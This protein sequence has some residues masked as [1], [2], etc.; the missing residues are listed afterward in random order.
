MTKSMPSTTNK[1]TRRARRVMAAGFGLATAAAVLATGCLEAPVASVTPIAQSVFVEPLVNAAVDKIDILFVIDN[2]RSMADKQA[3]LQDAVPRL[4]DRLVAPWCLDENDVLHPRN[5]APQCPEGTSP[6]FNAIDDMHIA[7]ITSS[8][9]IQGGNANHCTKPE[10]NDRAHLLPM[11]RGGSQSGL[12]DFLRWGPNPDLNAVGAAVGDFQTLVREAGEQGC[13]FEATMESWYRFL[14]QPDPGTERVAVPCGASDTGTNCIAEQGLDT[15]LLGQRKAFFTNADGSE[16]KNSLVAIVQLSDEN[17]CSVSA[18]TSLGHWATS[19]SILGNGQLPIPSTACASDPNSPCCYSC[20][21]SKPAACTSADPVCTSYPRLSKDADALN[22]RCWNQKQRFGMEFLY[23]VSRYID[24]LTESLVR[25]RDGVLQPNPL[26]HSDDPNVLIRDRSLVF[27]AGIIGVP[28]QDLTKDPTAP[29]LKYLSAEG[30]VD[31]GRWD[32]ILGNPKASPPVLASDI[33][34]RESVG[35]RAGDNPITGAKLPEANAING[36]DRPIINSDDLQ[37]ACTFELQTPK[38]CAGAGVGCDCGDAAAVGNPLCNGDMQIGA[39]AYPGT[40]FLE[41]LKGFSEVMYAKTAQHVGQNNAIVA[42][43]CPKEFKGADVNSDS[44]GYTPAVT[45]I[46]DRLKQALNGSCLPRALEVN[47]E[48]GTV[49]CNIVEAYPAGGEACSCG[50]GRVSVNPQT[51]KAVQGNLEEDGYCGG[52]SGD[53]CADDFC[54]CQIEQRTDP[55][56]DCMTQSNDDAITDPNEFGWCYIDQEI[57]Q[58]AAQQNVLNELGC[59][60]VNPRVLR[61][62]GNKVSGAVV[63]VAC[64]LKSGD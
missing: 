64:Q 13:G 42:S 44:Y 47:E 23:P 10:E 7:V 2:S 33:F 21:T 63:L 50:A 49:P 60:G 28:W 29:G 11:A 38:N 17:D 5:G 26:Y 14:I 3:V 57:H 61:I 30:L 36:G 27:L 51:L 58:D 16:R 12:N 4:L 9:G 35:Q 20:A 8:L 52:N 40:R 15:E 18:N 32:V 43:I 48:T 46:V 39:K 55:A 37:Y 25:D 53:S 54:Y 1:N 62:V 41:V 6:E 56:S 22:L 31:E 59:S 34:M 24:G 45:A 19:D